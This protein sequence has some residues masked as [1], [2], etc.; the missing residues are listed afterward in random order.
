MPQRPD[1]ALVVIDPQRAFVDPE[2]SVARTFGV[3]D[4]E[5]EIEVLGRLRDVLG[6][7]RPLAPTIYVRSEFEPGLFTG[8]DLNQGMAYVCVPGRGIDCEWAA[9]IEIAAH[10]VVV[11]KHQADATRSAPFLAAIDRAIAGGATRVAVAGFQ[12]TT[13]VLAT[14]ASAAG[15]LQPLGIPVA[16]VEPL[17]GS[18][19]SSYLRGPSGISRVDATRQQLR[20]AGVEVIPQRTGHSKSLVRTLVPQSTA[21]GPQPTVHSPEPEPDIDYCKK[22]IAAVIRSAF[23]KSIPNAPT[24]G[25][26]R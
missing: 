26:T 17:T 4:I 13:C 12:F 9:G 3:A 7:R 2:G 20:A 23:T 5:P 21:H 6:R 25:T 22:L 11:T 15:L 16:V 14:A 18:R 1:T 19:A 24:S 8:G 10:D